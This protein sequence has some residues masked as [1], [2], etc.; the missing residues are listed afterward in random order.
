MAEDIGMTV[1]NLNALAQEQCPSCKVHPHRQACCL[2][3]EDARIAAAFTAG[4]VVGVERC[5]LQAVAH[6]QK[7]DDKSVRCVDHVI[8]EIRSLSPDPDYIER[9]IRLVRDRVTELENDGISEA[10]WHRL[11]SLP[12]DLAAALR[13]QVETK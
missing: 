13:S 6:M 12:D 3:C 9:A 2:A 5:A 4:Q 11:S 1:T 8:E 10:N 7:Y